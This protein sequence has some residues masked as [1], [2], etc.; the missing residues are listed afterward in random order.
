MED[1]CTIFS[2]YSGVT[3]ERVRRVRP[4]I[5]TLVAV[6]LLMASP[7][8]GMCPARCECNESELRA[9]CPAAQLEV[10]PIQLNPEIKHINLSQN[11]INSIHYTFEFYSNL[12]TIDI[13]FNQ[14]QKLGSSNFQSQRHLNTLDLSHNSIKTLDRDVFKGLKSL[15]VLNLS[16]NDIDSIAP[17][18]FHDLYQLELLH[19]S[20]NS[21]VSFEDDL[22]KHLSNLR[23]LYLDNN[24]ILDIPTDNLQYMSK[25]E[26]LSL[27]KNLIEYVDKDSFPAL[28]TLKYLSLGVNVISDIHSNSFDGLFSLEHL[29]LSNN[30]LTT[31]LTS[32]LS[33]LSNLTTLELS[34]NYFFTIPPVAFRGLFKLQTLHLDRMPNLTKI[35][36]RA[37]VDNIKLENISLNDNKEIKMLPTRLFY[38][39]QRVVHISIADNGLSTLESTHF[40]LD[41]LLS[42]K[43][44]G[45]PFVC[46][47]SLMWLWNL[48]QE[49]SVRARQNDSGFTVDVN[50]I[51]CAGPEH[52][53]D[54]LLHQVEES[55]IRCSLSWLAVTALS[56]CSTCVVFIILVLV[57]YVRKF[58][59]TGDKM[60]GAR[61]CSG[62]SASERVAHNHDGV[63]PLY[64]EANTPAYPYETRQGCDDKFA[65][66]NGNGPP[67]NDYRALSPWENANKNITDNLY[68][69]Y[70]Y[71]T[72]R[73]YNSSKPHI[74]YV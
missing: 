17:N 10:V 60:T 25:L 53:A 54:K 71:N 62:R 3:G 40:P 69:H 58:K 57:F 19:L 33:K 31:V 56:T 72:S 11:K 30:N 70:G 73:T 52:L 74:V 47:C 51:S 42:L 12:I 39:N 34:G 37:F 5:A 32:Q 49:Q 20:D 23:I 64:H 26:T 50:R 59:C 22:F 35:D 7:V 8:G 66:A 43:L 48:E 4:L 29:D 6:L 18:S 65:P 24:Q 9:S 27:A 67:R 63:V 55:E 68:E 21:L 15:K 38:G 44:G 2:Q 16:F 28:N 45:N 1:V 14:I 36:Q 46:N 13:S 61:S 41:Q